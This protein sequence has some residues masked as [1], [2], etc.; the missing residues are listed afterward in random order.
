MLQRHSRNPEL[1]H[2]HILADLWGRRQGCKSTRY[3]FV[4]Q[5]DHPC[6][7]KTATGGALHVSS[8]CHIR[9]WKPATA[10]SSQGAER[11]AFWFAWWRSSSNDH[12]WLQHEVTVT[13]RTTVEGGECHAA[14]TELE[15][16]P[17]FLPVLTAAKML[18][19]IQSLRIIVQEGALAEAW[20]RRV[21]RR[22]VNVCHV[23]CMAINET[24]AS[25]PD[26]ACIDDEVRQRGAQASLG[27][28]C[29]RCH[30]CRECAERRAFEICTIEI[31]T[32]LRMPPL[33]LPLPPSDHDSIIADLFDHLSPV[34]RQQS[35]RCHDRLAWPCKTAGDA[36][37]R[38]Q[39]SCA[40]FH[41]VSQTLLS[42][43]RASPSRGK[44]RRKNGGRAWFPGS[45]RP[46]PRA[47]IEPS[48]AA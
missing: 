25:M 5:S 45:H 14:R 20:Q 16:E 3:F 39:I 1:K 28:H 47:G 33:L 44:P 37:I 34:W 40:P 9:G 46:E 23:R 17:L 38:N 13:I 21:G 43:R 31:H 10:P 15:H 24:E 2:K 42:A 18:E 8:P 41:R 7:Y 12:T 35:N 19:R 26:T 27:C 48:R 30:G 32:S 29:E 4:M 6:S 11:P 22:V 36:L